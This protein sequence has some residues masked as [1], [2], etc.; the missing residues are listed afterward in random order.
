M[1]APLPRVPLQ[2]TIL[3][4]TSDHGYHLGEHGIVESKGTPYEE[5]IRIPLV[6]RGPGVPVGESREVVS[7]VD[8]A[9]T[10]AAWA[11]AATPDFVDGRSME[12]VLASAPSPLACTRSSSPTITTGQRVP[13]ARR[14]SVRCAAAR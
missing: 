12:P 3:L 8:I 4:F 5:A 11:Q 6:V 13:T 10:I 2:D 9:P 1:N 7:L 14:R